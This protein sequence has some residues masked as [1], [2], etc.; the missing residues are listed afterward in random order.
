MFGDP[1]P[2]WLARDDLHSREFG[3]EVNKEIGR[4]RRNIG[5]TARTIQS[6]LQVCRAIVAAS[7]ASVGRVFVSSGRAARKRECRDA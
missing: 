6:N 2:L 7:Q 4:V 1:E 3:A 5:K